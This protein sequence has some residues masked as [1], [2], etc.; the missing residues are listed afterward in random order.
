[1]KQFNG[2]PSSGRV[3]FTPL[4]NVFFSSL[5]PQIDDI[6]ELKTTLHVMAVLYRKKGYPRYVTCGELLK[7]TSLMNSL[8]GTSEPSDEVLRGALEKAAGRG[9]MLHMV[10]DRDGASEDIYFLNDEASR[11]AV[12]KIQNGELELSGL[13]AGGKAYIAA[14]ARSVCLRG[15]QIEIRTRR[16]RRAS[17]T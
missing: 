2:F 17:I 1:M 5:L 10:L 3:E 14:D 7:N 9:T 15:K 6:A 12:V 16:S 11:Q 4:P 8:K 13:E